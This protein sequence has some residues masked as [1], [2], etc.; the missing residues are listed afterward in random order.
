MYRR[1]SSRGPIG[2]KIGLGIAAIL[3]LWMALRS[4]ASLFTSEDKSEAAALVQEFYK[5]EQV[6]DYGSAWELFHPLM[7]ERFSKPEYIQKRAHITM[8]DYGVA[9][10]QFSLGEPKLLAGWKMSSEA[11][12]L[13]GVYEII[14]TQK[15]HSPYGNFELIQPCYVVNSTG[16]WR[17]LWSYQDKVEE[18]AE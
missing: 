3:L 18:A 6:G 17:L 9:T 7:Q 14:V 15:F 10:F 5:D 4:G 1:R 13:Q 12:E 16:K 8:Q 2:L 11:A